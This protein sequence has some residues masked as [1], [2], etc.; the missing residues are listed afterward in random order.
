MIAKQIKVSIVI[1]YRGWHTK[2]GSGTCTITCFCV[3]ANVIM[4]IIAKDFG[5]IS[6]GMSLTKAEAE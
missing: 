2:T 4:V 3:K 5:T 1:A 6:F